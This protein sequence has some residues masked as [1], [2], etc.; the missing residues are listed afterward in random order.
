MLFKIAFKNLKKNFRFYSFYFVSV[1]LVF[2]VYCCFKSFALNRAVMTNISSDGRVQTMTGVVSIIF[3]AFVLFYMAYS[4]S[5]FTKR[6]IHELGIYAILGFKK[7]RIIKILFAENILIVTAALILGFILGSILHKGVVFILVSSLK[8]DHHLMASPLFN[9]EAFTSSAIFVIGALFLLLLSNCLLIGPST[10]LSMVRIEKKAEKPFKSNP[11]AAILSVVFLVSGYAIALN[12]TKGVNS[13]WVTI[14]FL[15]MAALT[16]LLVL[17]GTLLFIH[18]FLPF[19]ISF[20]RKKPKRFYKPNTII[21]LPKQAYRLRSNA[22]IMIMLTLVSAA[23]LGILGSTLCTYTFSLEGLSRI[24]PA[25]FEFSGDDPTK[26]AQARTLITEACGSTPAHLYESTLLRAESQTPNLP[27][28]EYAHKNDG[29]HFS[30]MRQSDF[31]ALM[32]LQHKPPVTN[33]SPEDAILTLYLSSNTKEEIGKMYDLTLKD[34][35]TAKV[36]IAASTLDNPLSFASGGVGVL[37][38]SDDFYDQ[39]KNT[40]LPQTKV[41]SAYGEQLLNNTYLAAELQALFFD[42]YRF[43]SA[44]LKK[45]EFIT[46]SSPNLLLTTFGSLI[47]FVAMGCI[48]YFKCLS[49]ALYDGSDFKILKRMGFQKKALYTLIRKEIMPIFY[50]PCILGGLHSFF[51]LIAYNALMPRIIPDVVLLPPFCLSILIYLIVFCLYFMFT[52]RAC[53]RVA[54]NA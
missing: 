7:T 35:S 46:A 29:S 48:L 2:S 42:D 44:N 5:F 22:R 10:V 17:L 9:L 50:I 18:F 24:T 53:C 4:N 37:I 19:S 14:G 39:L 3:M 32:Q 21:A 30:L 43:A 33:A 38:L 20:I 36:H 23:T 54:H 28:F 45:S 40:G 13:F 47:F 1:T 34:G 25:A 49:D 27:F 51:A 31:N 11:I 16:L 6:R 8:L 26:A 52:W 41:I 15:P 12:I